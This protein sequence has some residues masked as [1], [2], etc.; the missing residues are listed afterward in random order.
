[1]V[2][3]AVICAVALAVVAAVLPSADLLRGASGVGS[4]GHLAVVALANTV[5]LVAALSRGCR[6][7]LGDRR[8][9]HGA[10]AAISMNSPSVRAR[11]APGASRICRMCTPSANSTASGSK[12][13][14]RARAATSACTRLARP[15]WIAS[16]PSEPLD[17]VLVTGDMTDAGRSSEWAEFLDAVSRHPELA[18][19]IADDSRQPRPQ[20]RRS[21]QPG[22]AR[23]ADQP[24]QAAAQAAGRCRRWAWFRASAC[25]WSIARAAAWARLSRRR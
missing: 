16:M 25:M 3:G 11:A 5:V 7:G 9:D 10:A 4:A 24:E 21:R 13:G 1:M 17:V 19:R 20:H 22:P 2:S 15:N 18:E 23:S 8:R 12:A 14:G 6:P